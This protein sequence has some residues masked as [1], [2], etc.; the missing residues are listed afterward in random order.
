MFPVFL[1]IVLLILCFVSPAFYLLRRRKRRRRAAAQMTHELLVSPLSGLSLGAMLLG[2]QT[3]VQPDARPPIVEQQ[4]ED[5][6]EKES[7]GG[8]VFWRQLRQ[9]RKGED[10]DALK[11]QLNVD[12]T[13]IGCDL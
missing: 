10:V 6:G 7:P 1:V 13:T 9:I 4:V 12:E 3:I 5:E 8:M 11:V 2:L